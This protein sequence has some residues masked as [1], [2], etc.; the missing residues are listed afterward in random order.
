[1]SGDN[2]RVHMEDVPAELF[3]VYKLIRTVSSKLS[4][5]QISD[6][7]ILTLSGEAYRRFRIKKTGRKYSIS[8]DDANQTA[9]MGEY[10]S[11]LADERGFSQI[12]EFASMVTNLIRSSP[13]SIGR[14]LRAAYARILVNAGYKESRVYR[15]KFFEGLETLS[16]A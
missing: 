15:L 12:G 11:R 1:M 7:E 5:D 14:D 16:A 4:A 6:S 10:I 2:G 13:A 8:S 3:K 9:T